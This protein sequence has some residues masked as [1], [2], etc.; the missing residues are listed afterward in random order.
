VREPHTGTEEHPLLSAE[1]QQL[2]TPAQSPSLGAS[3]GAPVSGTPRAA[4]P[5]APS[6]L[7]SPRD[8][9]AAQHALRRPPTP[10]S[11]PSDQFSARFQAEAQR[12]GGDL[13]NRPAKV[14]THKPNGA[15]SIEQQLDR[16]LL[17]EGV[18]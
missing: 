8:V 14:H 6:P 18:P 12:L 3:P 16:H 7:E 4:D 13:P 17:L 5:S 1:K 2:L 15:C 11:A 10:A 9:P